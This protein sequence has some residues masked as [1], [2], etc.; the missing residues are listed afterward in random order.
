MKTAVLLLCAVA[1][2]AAQG[3]GPGTYLELSTNLCMSG[4]DPRVSALVPE[5]SRIH[6]VLRHPPRVTPRRYEKAIGFPY[7]Q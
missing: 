1:E 7:L 5:V 4:V 3:C 2:V 6:T